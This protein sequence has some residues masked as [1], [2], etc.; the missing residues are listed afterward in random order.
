[1]EGHMEVATMEGMVPTDN[2]RKLNT[3][4]QD[5]FLG[6]SLCCEKTMKPWLNLHARIVEDM[7]GG[8]TLFNSAPV[9]KASASCFALNCGVTLSHTKFFRKWGE[10]KNSKQAT[11]ILIPEFHLD[12]WTSTV[13]QKVHKEF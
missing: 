7:R 1:M 9:W 6:S 5:F 13:P 2:P 11:G 12:V 8:K 3:H 10:G 4:E